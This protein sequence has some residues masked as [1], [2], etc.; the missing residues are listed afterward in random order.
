M[1][2]MVRLEGEQVVVR[3]LTDADHGALETAMASPGVRAWWWDFDIG[4]FARHTTEPD[5]EP[6]VIEHA[7]DVVGYLQVSEEDSAQYR[8]AGI[9][10]ALRD[11]AQGRGLGSDAV[12][13]IAR[14][15]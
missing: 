15:L 6:F 14:F 11:D 12:R 7:D 1:T 4:D 10:L 8:F 3:S 9:D 13:T 2:A 5:V